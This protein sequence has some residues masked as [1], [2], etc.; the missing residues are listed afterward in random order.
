MSPTSRFILLLA[1]A[2]CFAWPIAG[3]GQEQVAIRTFLDRG[4]R[5]AW[6]RSTNINACDRRGKDGYFDVWVMNPDG[7]GK[8]N[9]AFNRRASI[10]GWKQSPRSGP[11]PSS[12]MARATPALSTGGTTW[13]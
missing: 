6:S 7:T 12:A 3:C 8:I 10:K 11:S 13:K 1:L 5:V 9:P 4:G 2:G